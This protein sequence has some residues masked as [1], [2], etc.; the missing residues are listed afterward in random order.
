MEMNL[1]TTQLLC[2]FTRVM[3]NIQQGYQYALMD[4]RIRSGPSYRRTAAP[5]YRRPWWGGVGSVRLSARPTVRPP[6][7]RPLVCSCSTFSS[8]I[9]TSKRSSPSRCFTKYSALSQNQ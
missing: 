7:Y 6:P 9:S 1:T 8:Q 3:E 2:C 5:P 4:I